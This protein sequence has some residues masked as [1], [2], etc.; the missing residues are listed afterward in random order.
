MSIVRG[1]GGGVNCGTGDD[2]SRSALVGE[3]PCRLERI[4]VRQNHDIDVHIIAGT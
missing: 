2:G 1:V 4:I 3:S